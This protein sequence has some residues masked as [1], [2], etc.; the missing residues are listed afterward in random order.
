MSQIYRDRSTGPVPPAVPT[1]FTTDLQDTDILSVPA[2][3]G[4]AV[5]QSNVLRVSGDNGIRTVATP[6]VAGNYT[7][8]FY[9]G[10]TTTSGAATSTVLSYPINEDTA[11]TIQIII[12]G[13]SDTSDAIGAYGTAVVKNVG[14]VASLINTVDLIV[15]SDTD[16]L[17]CVFE[18]GI[19]GTDL[20][21]NVTG[22]AGEDIAWT[23]CLPGVV[24]T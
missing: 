17:G 3:Q 21:I 9:R 22:V 12:A 14:G 11:L 8:R 18:V 23:A 19:S 7:V 10:D 15:N 2:S 4:T 24:G 5:P 20:Q 1:S 13:Y 16:L 6:N